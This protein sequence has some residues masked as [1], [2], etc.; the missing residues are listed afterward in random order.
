VAVDGMSLGVA[1]SFTQ[2]DPDVAVLV[3]IERLLAKTNYNLQPT[4][5]SKVDPSIGSPLEV[6]PL[7]EA[8]VSPQLIP[9]LS[10][11]KLTI[12]SLRPSLLRSLNAMWTGAASEPVAPK[13]TELGSTLAASKPLALKIATLIL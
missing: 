6:C 10:I 12:M 4:V 11:R 5:L 2:Y 7:R 1:S 8:D 9:V 3:G 13:R